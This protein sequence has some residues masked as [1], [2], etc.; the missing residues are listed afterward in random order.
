[1]RRRDRSTSAGTGSRAGHRVAWNTGLSATCRTPRSTNWSPCCALPRRT[2]ATFHGM[3]DEVDVAIVGGGVVGCAIASS[4]ARAGRSVLLLEAGPRLAE[5]VTSRNSGVIHSGLYYRPGSLKARTCVR[6]NALLYEWAGARGVAHAKMGKFVMARD[7][8]EV[9]D[10]EALEA[11]ARAAGAPGVRLV[12]SAFVRAREPALAAAAALWC[13]ETGIV[14]AVELAR[15]FAADATERG[16]LVLTQARVLAIERAGVSGY[17]LETARGPVRADRV[18]N[19]A[20]LY[21][22]EI[23]ALAGVTKYRIHPWRG[24]YFRFTP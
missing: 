12:S 15:S 23:A 13:P 24:D 18:V 6:G 3:D 5:G 14:D 8:Q 19:A 16:A 7:P 1:M 17:Q 22:D 9:P 21:A 4:L 2:A 11:N 20:G 10:L